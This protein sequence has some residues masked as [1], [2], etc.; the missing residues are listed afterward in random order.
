MLDFRK[1]QFL[2][3]PTDDAVLRTTWDEQ[4]R[5]FTVF[6]K[7]P[8]KAEYEIDYTTNLF[9]NASLQP[10]KISEKEYNDFN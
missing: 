6:V 8:G 1:P 5:K 2:Q 4:T 7:R 3:S 10:D 9:T